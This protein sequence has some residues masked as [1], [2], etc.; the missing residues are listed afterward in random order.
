MDSEKGSTKKGTSTGHAFLGFQGIEFTAGT[1]FARVLIGGG[2]QL[3]LLTIV[4]GNKEAA[5]S[6]IGRNSANSKGSTS[7]K[8]TC[9]SLFSFLLIISSSLFFTT[10]LPGTSSIDVPWKWLFTTHP[11]QSLSGSIRNL[12][13]HTCTSEIFQT[14]FEDRRGQIHF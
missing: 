4:E 7:P 6:R 12:I 13:K 3:N 10:A 8:T 9:L 11:I 5:T 1:Q 2:T 14:H